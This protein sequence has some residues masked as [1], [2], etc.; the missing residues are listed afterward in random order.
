MSRT[1]PDLPN[2]AVMNC[3]VLI[4]SY[5]DRHGQLKYVTST[6]GDVN[7]AQMLGLLVLGA[8]SLWESY[9]SEEPY[10]PDGKDEDDDSE[11]SEPE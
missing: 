2:G 1:V 11:H 10:E 9:M 3:E 5:F 7:I 6:S 8:I 4:T